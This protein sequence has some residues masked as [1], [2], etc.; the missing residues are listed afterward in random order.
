MAET[1]GLC[2]QYVTA[3]LCQRCE[4]LR[5]A[6]APGSR[7]PTGLAGI[8][9]RGLP[10]WKEARPGG[11]TGPGEHRPGGAPARVWDALSH[12]PRPPCPAPTRPP[13]R[14]GT[15]GP[16]VPPSPPPPRVSAFQT[17]PVLR[18]HS[19][20]PRRPRGAPRRSPSPPLP[21]PR[22]SPG[23]KDDIIPPARPPRRSPGPNTPPQRDGGSRPHPPFTDPR[24]SGGIS[25]GIWGV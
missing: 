17:A 14:G 15:A 16:T 1:R 6:L 20:K 9:R 19:F 7:A 13:L 22:L 8:G 24:P 23:E 18:R 21:R 11:S 12:H 3:L 10:A 2:A 4:K 5:S 25:G